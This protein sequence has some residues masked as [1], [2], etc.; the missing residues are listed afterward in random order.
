MSSQYEAGFELG[1]QAMRDVVDVANT[2]TAQ[3]GRSAS[4]V[5]KHLHDALF[6]LRD[7]FEAN[8]G[9]PTSRKVA[10]FHRPYPAG[11]HD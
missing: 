2:I 4:L 8:P 10:L 1:E 7:D 5:V 3:S 11:A 9:A 6:Y